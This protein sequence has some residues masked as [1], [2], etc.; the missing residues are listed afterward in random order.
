[1][2]RTRHGHTFEDCE[3]VLTSIGYELKTTKGSHHTFK[4]KKGNRITIAR[5]R[6]VSPAAI[7]D[8][9]KAWDEE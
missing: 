5:H 8:V 7:E 3:K 9:I 1:M 6:P 2:K 4:N